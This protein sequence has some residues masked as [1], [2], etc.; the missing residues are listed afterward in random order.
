MKRKILA[1]FTAL[2]AIFACTAFFAAC[3]EQEQFN[4]ILSDDGTYYIC[5][6]AKNTDTDTEIVI[7]SEYKDKPVGEVRNFWCDNLE[8][9]TI[10]DS[11]TKI[12]WQG[13]SGNTK[14]K[15][16]SIGS[17]VKE[18]G[19][20]AF[21]GCTALESIVIPDNVITIGEYAFDKCN[22]LKDISLGKGIT[23]I[24]SYTFNKCENLKTVVLPD[25]VKVIN[26]S[27]FIES[28]IESI[29]FGKGLTDIGE[30]AFRDCKNLKS[31]TLPDNLKTIGNRAFFDCSGLETV[32]L[33]GKKEITFGDNI[34]D[35][36]PNFKGLF[37]KSSFEDWVESGS[38]APVKIH[39]YSETE[40][41]DDSCYYWHYVDEQI[42][43]WE[44]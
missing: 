9:V 24:A 12:G 42:T 28:G 18:I 5:E 20:Q 10:P 36:C 4:F 3:S 13:F 44:N 25:N 27:A 23:A 16:V 38:S 2:T 11:V 26:N 33:G 1:L 22:N 7:P 37:S 19:E 30:Y 31:I 8:S 39:F 14:L 41:T 43:V 34:F 29:T 15:N 35:S 40:P 6:A 21:G 32:V 17:G